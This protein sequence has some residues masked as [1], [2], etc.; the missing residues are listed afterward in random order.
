MRSAITNLK[1]RSQLLLLAICLMSWMISEV[2]AQVVI[3]SENDRLIRLPRPTVSPEFGPSRP[4]P[5][6]PYWIEKLRIDSSISQQVAR[7]QV[8]QQIKNV[9]NRTIQASFV[10][11]LPYDG[12][13]DRMTFLVDG[14]EYD[15]KLLDAKEARSIYENYVRQNQDPALLEFIGNGMFRTSVFPIPA[16]ASRT[17]T[18]RYSQICRKYNGLTEWTFPLR[19]AQFT[20]RPIGSFELVVNVVEESKIKNIYSPSHS[21]EMKRT[22]AESATVKVA[23]K[24]VIPTSDFRLFYDTSGKQ[25]GVNVIS[26]RR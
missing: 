23:Q 1:R 20:T 10:F 6:A 5:S 22:S 16:N 24:H 2:R 25:L 15:A 26:Y 17:V 9:S 7:V 13:V 12:A 11:P 19:A 4:V 21:L 14:K 8:T 18:I 3:Q